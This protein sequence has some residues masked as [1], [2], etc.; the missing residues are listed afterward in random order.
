MPHAERAQRAGFILRWLYGSESGSDSEDV[1]K[2]LRVLAELYPQMVFHRSGDGWLTIIHRRGLE[3][4]KVLKF[5][6]SYRIEVEPESI[7]VVKDRE[8][9]I[10][11]D[12]RLAWAHFQGCLG[13]A[14]DGIPGPLTLRK[15]EEVYHL[16][17]D[18]VPEERPPRRSV[19]ER[20]LEDD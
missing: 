9:H 4:P 14:P 12:S 13:L 18:Y 19:W 8:G 3:I 11:G 15:V 16:P 6:A 17:D 10:R 20:L 1:S 2:A 7:R 5:H